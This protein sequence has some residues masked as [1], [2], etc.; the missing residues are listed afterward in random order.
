MSPLSHPRRLAIVFAIVVAAILVALA[1]LRA[2]L[3]QVIADEGTYLAMIESLRHD[4][5]LEFKEADRLRIAAETARGRQEVILHRAP[6]GRIAY[7]KPV[8]FPVL[9]LPFSALFGEAGPVA[10]NALALV[11]AAWLALR[12]LRALAARDGGDPG[13]GDFLLVTFLGAAVIVPYVFWRMGD[14]LQMALALAGL[15]LALERQRLGDPGADRVNARELLGMALLA[16][17]L[18]L[19]ISNGIMVIAPIGAALLAR[20][21]RRAAGLAAGLAAALALW[22]GLG[23]LLTGTTNPYRE[24]RTGFM[25]ETGYPTALPPAELDHRFND[26]RRSHYTEVDTPGTPR[27]AA[28]AGLYFLIGRHTGL[29]FYFPAAILLLALGLRRGDAVGWTALLAFLGTAA[30]FVGWKPDNYFGGETFLGNRYLIS[31]YP[32]AL[33]VAARLPSLRLML[34]PWLFAFLSY[35]SALGSELTKVPGTYASQSHTSQG[36]FAHLPIETEA[37]FLEGTI[38][39]YWAGQLV[40]FVTPPGQVNSVNFEMSS[41]ERPTE[42]V[43]AQWEIPSVLRF[44]VDAS[45]PEAT[46]EVEDYWRDQSFTVGKAAPVQTLIGVPVDLRPSRPWRR[47]RLWFSDEPYYLRV[48]K[49]R[50]RS[51]RPAKAIVTFFGDPLLLEQL[52]DYRLHRLDWPEEPARAGAPGRLHLEIEN[53]GARTWQPDDPAAVVGR[54]RFFRVLPEGGFALAADSGRL[55]LP[56]APVAQTVPIDLP[57][58][59]PQ[60]PG[61]YELEVDLILDHVAWFQERLGHPVGR[62]R[63]EV[64]PAGP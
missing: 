9:S 28:F 38:D 25:P 11:L 13:L 29:F 17:V 3:G 58:T 50:L 56:V 26:F 60:E 44:V 18:T 39:R 53:R 32:L 10:L 27:E 41:E 31:Y 15:T 22:A 35:G 19:R 57:L 64:L 21:F 48:L 37:Q 47:H 2:P 20:R 51:P 52:I 7:S 59:W 42:I 49:L 14:S 62:R 12:Y 54:W 61:T 6:D 34:L 24:V 40:R 43:L 16:A 5:D 1:A 23:L 46:F 8:L 55:P 63:F 4:G 45:V 30:F 33:F 36:I